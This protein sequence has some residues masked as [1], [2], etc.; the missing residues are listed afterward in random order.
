MTSG[1]KTGNNFNDFPEIVPTGEITT[2][3][4]N[5][6]L[7]FSSVAVGRLFLESLN[8]P[9]AAASKVPTSIRHCLYI[10]STSVYIYIGLHVWASENRACVHGTTNKA[11]TAV[12]F[13]NCLNTIIITTISSS[14]YQPITAVTRATSLAPRAQWPSQ[15]DA[16]GSA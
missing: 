8:E 5:I 9:K 16:S 15:D 3:I 4:E 10:Y 12:A 11:T 2:K 6:F 7:V 13:H 1:G 14:S